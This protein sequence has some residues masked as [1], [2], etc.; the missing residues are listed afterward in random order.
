M[1]RE[2]F[3]TSSEYGNLTPRIY[4]IEMTVESVG[5]TVESAGMSHIHK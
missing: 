1:I 2:I 3:I 5:T 4:D